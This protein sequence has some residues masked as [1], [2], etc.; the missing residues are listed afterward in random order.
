MKNSPLQQ[1]IAKGWKVR[2]IKDLLDY[3]RPDK[4]IVENASYNP[5]G[6]IPVLTAN[7]SFI[8]GY[9][10]ETEG[11]YINTPAIIFDD[12][13]T[14]SKYVDF[15]FKVKSSAIKIL[16][17][18]NK[19]VDLKFVYEIIKSITFQIA[20][21]KRHYI[22]QYQ[23]LEIVV[24]SSIKEQE[25][26]A[27]ILSAID[28]EIQK[29]ESLVACTSKLK[30]GVMVD[31]LSRGIGHKDFKKS[32]IG[33][34]PTK[35]EVKKFGEIASLSTGTTP[36]TSNKN[37]YQG[38]IPFIKT[39]E[40]VNSRIS[41]TNTFISEEAFV[42]YGLKKYKPG[43]ILLAMYGQG[44]TRGQSALLDIEACTT[45]NAAAIVPSDKINS[46]FLWLFLLSQYLVLREGGKKGHISHLSLS[47]M[48]NVFVPVPSMEEQLKISQILLAIDKKILIANELRLKFLKLKNGVVTDLLS[49]RVRVNGI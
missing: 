6:K 45:Q 28:L 16:K 7:K 44:K 10:E 33:P 31:L 19:D 17:S 47:Y 1:N 38:N 4:Y 3:E 26:I 11:V 29:I 35:W 14:D 24:P 27:E 9:T 18:K 13:T 37:Y 34:V 20:N 46:E 39:G 36:S 49:G 25:K 5:K 21:H 30:K 43:T 12:F 23:E 8:L 48:K 40:I 42:A 32:E 41:N 2:K 15:P 22:S